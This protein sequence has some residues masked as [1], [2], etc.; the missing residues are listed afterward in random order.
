MAKSGYHIDSAGQVASGAATV[1][2]SIL[3]VKATSD[4]AID[5]LSYWAELDGISPSDK[6]ILFEICASTFATQPPGTASSALTPQQRRGRSP[7]T[8]I[9]AAKN[10]TTEPTVLTVIDEFSLDPNKG[11]WRMDESL[12]EASDSTLGG[13][14]VMRATV[15]SGGTVVNIRAGM[16]VERA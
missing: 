3:G 14:F 9:S 12:G 4:F 16:R 2:K 5:L 13:G 1:A 7:A 11:I 8:G 10:W 6:P 15:P